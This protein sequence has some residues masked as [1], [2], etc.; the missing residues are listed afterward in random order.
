M[1]DDNKNTEYFDQIYYELA[2][3]EFKLDNES[4]GLVYMKKSAR[5]STKN[6]TQKTKTYLFLADYY[7]TKRSISNSPSLLRQYNC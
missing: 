6:Q 7:F 2:K 3:L 1:L 4:D 5:N